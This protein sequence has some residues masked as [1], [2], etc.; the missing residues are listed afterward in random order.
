ML[1]AKKRSDVMK[2]RKLNMTL[3][4]IFFKRLFEELIFEGACYGKEIWRQNQLAL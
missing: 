1:T 2:F 4:L 3:D